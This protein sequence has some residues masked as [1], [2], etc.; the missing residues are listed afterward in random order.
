MNKVIPHVIPAQAGIQSIIKQL[1]KRR[2][3][4][5]QADGESML[6][7]LHPKDLVNYQR[8]SFSKIKTNDLILAFKKNL[9]FTHRVIYKT[10]KYLITKGDNNLESDGK[11]SPNQIIGRVISV[12]RKNKII[13]PEMVY[14]IQ[15]S[16]YFKEIVKIIDTFEKNNIN[17]V[18]L[19]G[20]PVH[21]YYEKSHPRRIYQDADILIDKPH[22]EKAVEILTKFG[23]RSADSSLSPIQKKFKDKIVEIAFYKIVNGFPVVFDIHL[24][25]AFMMTQIGNLEALYPQ[26]LINELT[27]EMLKNK[28]EIKVNNKKF[29]IL[30][31]SFLIL[32]LALHFFHHN[33]T[34][35]F[36]LEFLDL[37][38]RKNNYLMND[39]LRDS[40]KKYKLQNFVS[41][42]FY[43]LKKYYQT[44][45]L[46]STYH[47][48]ILYRSSSIF[49]SSGIKRFL[50]LFSLSP[51][52]FYKK[53][54]VF[55]NHQV[56]YLMLFTL[57][58]KLKT[59][60]KNCFN[61]F[62]LKL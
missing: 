32:Y 41:P 27:Q 49:D 20:L 19:K 24:D 18:F 61:P 4:S 50:L 1:K 13:D 25:P 3:F 40:I 21:L 34:G 42:V 22:F 52:P 14:L 43:L 37:V 45:F 16:L 11:I 7:L 47:P 30:N 2:T 62:T 12:K 28:K 33:F 54:F 48:H 51:F 59:L 36:R 57:H 55:I 8:I 29:F 58:S 5:L 10:D 6:P 56:I 38:I 23:Y 39:R 17:Y 15:S 35:A 9:A 26:K 44:P 53:I 31:S 60:L 46:F